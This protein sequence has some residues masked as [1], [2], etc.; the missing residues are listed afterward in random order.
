M[1]WHCRRVVRQLS[2][3][4]VRLCFGM[5]QRLGPYWHPVETF[6]ASHRVPYVAMFVLSVKVDRASFAASV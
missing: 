4:I 2:S 6:L 3:H 1:T 5:V